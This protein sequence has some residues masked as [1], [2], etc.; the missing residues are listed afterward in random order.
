MK[1]KLALKVLRTLFLIFLLFFSYN[2]TSIASEEEYTEIIDLIK[3]SNSALK[4]ISKNEDLKDF[5]KYLTNSKAILIFPEVYEGS[6]FFGAKAGNGILL[7]KNGR[8]WSGPFFYTIGG[9]SVGLQFGIKSG[10]VVMTVM[11]NRGLKSILKERVKLGVDIDA[12]VADQGLGFSAETT[13]RLADV[14]SFS[15][16]SGLFLG[17]SFEGTYLQPRNDFNTIIHKKELNADDILKSNLSH[18]SIKAISE[19]FNKIISRTSEK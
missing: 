5:K 19:S 2:S 9:V 3:A 11:S 7:I 6:F 17:G 18:I 10:K 12:A 4:I 13:L 1:K 14:F 15:D 16:N 8:N